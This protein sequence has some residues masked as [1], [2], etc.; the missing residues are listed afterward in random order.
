[1]YSS[2]W[3]KKQN[4]SE[5]LKKKSSKPPTSHRSYP[6]LL[7]DVK[8][9]ITHQDS[10]RIPGGSLQVQVSFKGRRLVVWLVD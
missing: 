5:K 6:S 4:T 1:M 2:S 10:P 9:R 8:R 7:E 3:W